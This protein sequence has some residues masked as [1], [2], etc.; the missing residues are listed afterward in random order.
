VLPYVIR[1]LLWGVVLFFALTFVVFFLFFVL[2]SD[3]T[4]IGRGSTAVEVD[5]R[6]AY[7]IEGPLL[8][9]YGEFIWG[10]L[11][12]GD[13]G[14]SVFNGQPVTE[15]VARA[16]PVTASLM[17]GGVILWLGI[18]LPVGILSALRP[19]S[20]LDRVATVFVLVGIS[21]HPVWIGY[22]LSYTFGY[23]LGWFPFT[24]Y[25]DFINPSGSCGGP[26]QWTYSLFLPWLSV[27]FLF[28]ALYSRMIRASVLETLNEDYVRT[29]RA[30][31]LSELVV[32]RSHVLRTSLLPVVTMLGMD[33]GL[34]FGAAVFIETVFGL[35]GL[36]ALLLPSLRRQ[37]LPVVVGLVLVVTTAIIVFN[38]IVDLL[39]ARLDPRVRVS[40]PS[41]DAPR[42]RGLRLR[43]AAATAVT[44]ATSK[45]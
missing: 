28:A 24:G 32:V 38:L 17:L 4:R 22:V 40:G 9:E 15:I 6:D 10:I 36:G 34:A 33:V 41:V 37:D 11:R 18:A 14:R 26:V 43:A 23:E 20:L 16:A 12:H 27:A 19:R 25:C 30:K 35:P 42:K 2:P 5:I 13:L 31:G 44:A 45:R 1:R 3:P 7:R 39:Y 21:A 29:A 8:E